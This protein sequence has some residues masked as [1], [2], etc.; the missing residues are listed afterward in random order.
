MFSQKNTKITIDFNDENT[1]V[2][3][4]YQGGTGYV[5]NSKLRGQGAL[6]PFYS[7]RSFP[8]NRVVQS[9]MQSV[10]PGGAPYDVAV[11]MI[12]WV[13]MGNQISTRL[14]TDGTVEFVMW[15]ETKFMVQQI[16]QA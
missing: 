14:F 3:H 11:L 4:G 2:W 5:E 8:S 1:Y 15:A 6:S 9:K 12:N 7:D 16:V 10:Q 13:S